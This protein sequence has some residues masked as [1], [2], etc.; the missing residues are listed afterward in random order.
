MVPSTI[1]SYVGHFAGQKEGAYM[2]KKAKE[3]SVSAVSKLKT[4][5]RYAVGG[6]D[7]LH[8]RIVGNSRTWVLRVVVGTRTNSKGKIVVHRRDMGLGSYPE[9]SL[10]EARDKARELRK[11]VRS[12]IDPLE[13]KKL[14]EEALRIQKRRAK[15]FRECACVVMENKSRELK[16][17][18]S[19]AS[20]RASI[21]KHVFPVL[22]DRI[23]GTITRADVAAVLE[24]IW[25]TKHKTAKELRGRIETILDYA[26][27][28]EYREGENPAAWKG[29]IEPILGRVKRTVKPRPSLPYTETGAFMT[30]LQKH[31]GMSARALEFVIL[32]AARA[33]EVFGAA[34]EEINIDAGI[35]T[36]PAERM[37][38]GKEHRVPLSDV[39]V[40]LLK[41]LPR[42]A[43]PRYIFPAFRGGL[44]SHTTITRLIRCMHESDIQAGGKGFIDPKQNCV[45]TTHGFRSTFRDWAAE[46]TA[47]P[48][49]V[50]EHALAHG[51]MNKVE[52]AYQRGDL[53]AKRTRLMT[54][55]ARYCGMINP[56]IS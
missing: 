24:P 30:E 8:L 38:A 41:S 25:R 47:Y 52:A 11:Q 49:E 17:A 10:A 13:Q 5:G 27:A 32:T 55:W 43:N 28:M 29:V 48:R 35:W 46:T 15:T 3:L 2:P 37:K 40:K 53:L 56:D 54:D 1:I 50:C 7:G 9:I 33:G 26:K 42:I 4:K 20:W 18:K 16:T 22:G 34:W 39:A 51:L 44:M 21:E 6:A 14:N 23:V 12:G 36:I 45:I 31:E 19:M